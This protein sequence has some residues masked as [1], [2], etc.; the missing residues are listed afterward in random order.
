MRARYGFALLA[1]GLLLAGST[2]FALHSRRMTATQPAPSR[3]PSRPT[4]ARA[5]SADLVDPL[6][7]S[8]PFQADER[9]ADLV[10]WVSA[11]PGFQFSRG[12]D[13]RGGVE[14]C[15]TQPVD[16][17]SFSS[18]LPL[19]VGKLT[20]PNGSGVDAAGNFDLVVHLHGDQ[21][22]RRELTLS[23]QSF[24][25]AALTLPEGESYASV[26]AGRAL[27]SLIAE[28]EQVAGKHLGKPVHARHVVLTAWSAGFTGV[29][30]VLARQDRAPVDAVV[31]VDGLHAP[32][33]DKQAFQVQLQ[34]FVDYAK[35]A[36]VGDGFFLVTHSS[37]DPPGF[38]S[39]TECAHY[40]IDSLAG[41]PRAVT[42]KDALGLELV[43]SFDRGN[44]HV[45]GYAGNNKADHCAQLGTLRDAF[46]ALG[47][48]FQET[49]R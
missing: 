37:I 43:E 27:E 17:S 45:R 10:G 3:A 6:V 9:R 44:F 22:V 8:R 39:T 49:A 4:A 47:V 20:V 19:R 18:W 46:S 23:R 25:L 33:G 15:S 7:P 48:R 16:S 2:G 35:R 14:P 38:A 32:R 36:A 21:P 12:A 11:R 41:A 1:L 5:T 40:L 24:V 31:L 30:A 26:L 42:R 29:A 28:T 34:P 13:E